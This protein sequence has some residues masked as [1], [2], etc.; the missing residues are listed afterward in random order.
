MEAVASRSVLICAVTG[1]VLLQMSAN[2][3]HQEFVLGGESFRSDAACSQYNDGGISRSP[4]GQTNGI[5]KPKKRMIRVVDNSAG[6]LGVPFTVRNRLAKR[7]HALFR[8]VISF[9]F[10]GLGDG[11][12]AALAYADV[13]PATSLGPGLTFA[14]AD[15]DGDR[16][17][18]LASIQGT[19]NRSGSSDYSIQIHL[20][21]LGRQSIHL[22]AP[23]GGLLIQARDVDG[24]HTIDLV[25]STAWRN[26]PVA[27]FLNDG[28]GS[29]SRVQVAAFPGA[30]REC[31][32]NLVPAPNP[33]T[34]AH[35]ISPQP[36]FGI[37]PGESDSGCDRTPASLILVSTAGFPRDP[38]QTSYAGRAPPSEVHHS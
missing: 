12:T 24:D 15:F 33:G 38:F 26:Q 9:L 8:F 32:T 19:Q 4:R 7:P 10:F 14:I 23:V 34:D 36:G 29:F 6:K 18:D 21:E 16:R 35:G 25:V 37:C 1:E 31:Q 20:S 17:P 5:V 30:F 22:V 27:I 13:P 11:G 2:A 28:H 3:T